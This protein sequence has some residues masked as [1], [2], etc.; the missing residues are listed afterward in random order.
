MTCVK[1]G[2][3]H[4]IP[5][6]RGF[7]NYLWHVL[8]YGGPEEV[9]ERRRGNDGFPGNKFHSVGEQEDVAQCQEWTRPVLI[10]GGWSWNGEWNSL[11]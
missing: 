9:H 11:R 5:N 7:P 8:D 2:E 4:S 10:L 3:I 6:Y 1:L